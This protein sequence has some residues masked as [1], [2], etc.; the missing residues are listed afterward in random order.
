[1]LHLVGSTILLYVQNSL[2]YQ[3]SLEMG[4]SSRSPVL[5]MSGF[6]CPS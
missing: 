1:L 3:Q 6:A 5:E 2:F 4:M